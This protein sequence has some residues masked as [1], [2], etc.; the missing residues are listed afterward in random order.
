MPRALYSGRQLE[1]C[2]SLSL[3]PF[4]SFSGLILVLSQ[5]SQTDKNKLLS[6]ITFLIIGLEQ[7]RPPSCKQR[8]ISQRK[9]TDR[10]FVSAH[11]SSLQQ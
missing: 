8:M 10:E 4:L 7:I 1:I 2:L 5:H 11:L 6:I 3:S 9:P